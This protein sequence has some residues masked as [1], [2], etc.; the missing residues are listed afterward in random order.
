MLEIWGERMTRHK[1]I[2]AI[3]LLLALIGCARPA[4]TPSAAQAPATDDTMH[5]GGDGG[6]GGDG[7]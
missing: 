5:G 3:L 6:G 2:V 4:V 1:A 7:M